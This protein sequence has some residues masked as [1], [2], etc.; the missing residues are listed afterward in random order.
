MTFISNYY[1][2][3]Y[4]IINNRLISKLSYFIFGR[5]EERGGR[6]ERKGEGEGKG[7][8]VS[9]REREGEKGG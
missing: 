2:T 6:R 8:G 5:G 4:F 1:Y 3:V 9:G 7:E